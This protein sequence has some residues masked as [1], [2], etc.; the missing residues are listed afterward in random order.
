MCCQL[1]SNFLTIGIS[2]VS[3]IIPDATLIYAEALNSAAFKP[4]VKNALNHILDK[5]KVYLATFI[6]IIIIIIFIYL[7]SDVISQEK[8]CNFL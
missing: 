1:K 4:V 3:C 2:H 7:P 8:N 5:M 6:I